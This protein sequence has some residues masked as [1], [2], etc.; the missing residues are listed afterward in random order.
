MCA[1]HQL[2]LSQPQSWLVSW[3]PF[4]L[5][6]PCPSAG[7]PSGPCHPFSEEQP[8]C[9]LPS[10]SPGPLVTIT[11]RQ[12]PTLSQVHRPCALQPPSLWLQLIQT[13]CSPTGRLAVLHTHAA[14]SHLQPPPLL[15][16]QPGMAF[17]SLPNAL[18]LHVLP[19]EWGQKSWLSPRT[20]Q[21]PQPQLA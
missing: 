7:L 11:T 14:P 10:P 16:S 12:S 18:V 1:Y 21:L 5:H 4:H 3:G 17:L 20:P 6:R 19:E 8:G 2:L 9:P 15:H 13:F